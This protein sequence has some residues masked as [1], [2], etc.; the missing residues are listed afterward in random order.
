MAD[1][2]GQVDAK[3]ACEVA[4]AGRHHMLFHGPPGV[5]KTMLAERVPGLLPDLDVHDGLEVSAVHSLAGFNL[6]DELITRPPYCD[7]HHSASVPA[8]SA[9]ASEWRSSARFRVRR[10][11]GCQRSMR[12]SPNTR[13]DRSPAQLRHRGRHGDP[14]HDRDYDSDYGD[15]AGDSSENLGGTGP[16][17]P[18]QLLPSMA[19]K[20]HLELLPS[21]L[22]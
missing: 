16:Q 12:G 15:D 14:T 9:V 21:V 20:H 3:W 6:A 4:A 19:D 8:S 13:A 11:S 2:V 10:Q 17:T 18:I 5:G 1:V 22:A 7:P